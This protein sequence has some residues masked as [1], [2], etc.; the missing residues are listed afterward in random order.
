LDL[1]RGDGAFRYRPDRI[2]ADPVAKRATAAA[3]KAVDELDAA[4]AE[5]LKSL[6]RLRLEL[7]KTRKVPAYV[8]FSDRS[9]IDMAVKRPR[10]PGE[11]AQV[12]GVGAAKQE[13]FAEAFLR[14][15]AAGATSPCQSRRDL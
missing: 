13:K 1:L 9:L 15:I 4:A 7:A 12:F 11:F 8:I 5:L 2:G 10:T 3:T 14:V 6:K